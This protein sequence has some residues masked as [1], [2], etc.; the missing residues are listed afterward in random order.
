MTATQ[1]IYIPVKRFH[2][3]AR[4]TAEAAIA[5]IG[6][7]QIHTY[8][9]NDEYEGALLTDGT[10]RYSSRSKL[11]PPGAG[12]TDHVRVTATDVIINESGADINTRI[13]S[14]T[15]NDAF[16]LEGDDGHIGIK[17]NVLPAWDTPYAVI[18]YGGNCSIMGWE[19]ALPNNSQL[20]LAVNAF[21]NGATW[22]KILNAK[23]TSIYMQNNQIEIQTAASGVGAFVW[24]ENVVFQTGHS[25][26]NASRA[27]IDFV[28][29]TDNETYALFV[30]GS[31]DNIGMGTQNPLDNL[32]GQAAF[33]L[34]GHGLHILSDSGEECSVVI[35]GWTPDDGGQPGP[36][37]FFA[38][39]SGGANDKVISQGLTDTG[40]FRFRSWNDNMTVLMDD[41]LN[42]DISDGG[43]FMTKLKAGANQGAAG[44]GVNELWVDTG[45]QTIKLGT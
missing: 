45:D 34:P 33:D 12:L 10:W 6:H 44:A 22:N 13:E 4:S 2:Y 9:E 23:A 41:I 15:F 25:W 35:D 7:N 17:T 16:F 38:N 26:F 28:V 39:Q 30:E 8:I 1:P 32:A 20:F 40:L 29:S 21:Y 3:S 19:R 24:V 31:T 36:R 11:F 43:I 37:L 18:N 5:K 27:D 14:D 42:I